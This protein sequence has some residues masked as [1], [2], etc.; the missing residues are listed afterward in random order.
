M[1]NIVSRIHWPSWLTSSPRS[2]TSSTGSTPLYDPRAAALVQQIIIPDLQGS[3]AQPLQRRDRSRSRE[4]GAAFIDASGRPRAGRRPSPSQIDQQRRQK[5]DRVNVSEDTR[6]LLAGY[7]A[8]IAHED[9]SWQGGPNARDLANRAPKANGDIGGNDEAIRDLREEVSKLVNHRTTEQEF[10]HLRNRIRPIVT[11]MIA[12]YAATYC[13]EGY[14]NL[15]ADEIIAQFDMKVNHSGNSM[16]YKEAMI[17]PIM[18]FTLAYVHDFPQ[19]YFMTSST[20]THK[21]NLA[22]VAFYNGLAALCIVY[23]VFGP[24]QRGKQQS[25]EYRK[26]IK[27][28]DEESGN[29]RLLYHIYMKP[30]ATMFQDTF[31][32]AKMR[33]YGILECDIKSYCNQRKRL[34]RKEG[35]WSA[36]WLNRMNA[37]NEDEKSAT[38]GTYLQHVCTLSVFVPGFVEV[39]DDISRKHGRWY[40][41]ADEAIHEHD[42]DYLKKHSLFDLEAPVRPRLNIDELLKP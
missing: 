26:L 40:I 12:K 3:P 14:R 36:N 20:F 19:K 28:T 8:A 7:A 30:I 17:E 32:L 10:T 23:T 5:I 15:P 16:S 18:W 29:C 33:D 6:S 22:P 24:N 38:N 39:I 34:T 11:A 25:E 31:S 4:R 1:G 21:A 9:P 13:P 41:D 42:I 35:V 37:P 27:Y 2:T